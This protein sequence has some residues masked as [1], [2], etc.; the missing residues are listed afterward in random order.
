MADVLNK[1]RESNSETI[2][3]DLRIELIHIK[4]Y[5]KDIK[6]K[7]NTIEETLTQNISLQSE[8]EPLEII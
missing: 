6:Q 4:K 7:I 5:I 3:Q 2:L 8:L 1:F